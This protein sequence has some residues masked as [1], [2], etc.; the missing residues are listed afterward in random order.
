MLDE[1]STEQKFFPIDR[2]HCVKLPVLIS[3]KRTVVRVPHPKGRGV[4]EL[5][6]YADTKSVKAFLVDFHTETWK[7][8]GMSNAVMLNEVAPGQ[9]EISPIFALSCVSA[10]QKSLYQ[11]VLSECASK[12]GLTLLLHKKPFAFC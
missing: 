4:S 7:L 12:D 2:E 8:G 11:D 1:A 6:R 3:C 5:L 9:H 10:G